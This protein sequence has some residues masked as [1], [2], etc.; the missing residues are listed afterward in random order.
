MRY[1][2]EDW[3]F[4]VL[5]IYNYRKPGPFSHYFDHI[6][7]NHRYL[8]GD[9][10]EAGVF[11][12]SSLLATALL[13]RELG[14]DKLVW[15]Y[16]T[17]A[18]FPQYHPN[19]DI[20]MFEKLHADGSISDAHYRK[21]LLNQEYRGLSIGKVDVSTVSSSGDFSNTSLPLLERKIAYLGLENIRLV[22]GKFADTMK[23][24]HQQPFF[25]ALL[26]CDLYE[27]YTIALPFIWNNLSVGG[28]IYID[29]YYSLK[30]PGAR[31]ATDEFFADKPE[32]PQQHHQIPGDFERWFVRKLSC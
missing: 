6:I 13:L 29:E 11:R 21:V 17:F 2:Y 24:D 4:N 26:D 22:P 27:S 18:G 30:F 5:G 16:D 3:E 23:L 31:I 9:V 20:G 10:C 25:A 1:L 14:S 7:E 32:K 15:G 8:P 19:D 28:Y 12:G